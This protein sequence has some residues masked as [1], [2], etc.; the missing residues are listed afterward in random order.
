MT[1]GIPSPPL[2]LLAAVLYKAHLTVVSRMSGSRRVTNPRGSPGHWDLVLY[3]S[4][5]YSFHLFLVSVLLLGLY[6]FCSLLCPS[7]SEVFLWYL[8]FSWRG[9]WSFPFC[10]F[11]LLLCIVHWRRAFLSLLAVLWNS[12]F[13]WAYLSLSSLLFTSLLSSAIC[14][15]SL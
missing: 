12:A 11:P 6:R 7:L 3:S 4:S 5:V 8:Q 1:A 13:R 10:C 9:L 15:A 2:A 14:K